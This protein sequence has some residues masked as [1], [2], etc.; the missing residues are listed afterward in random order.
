MTRPRRPQVRVQRLWRQATA[1][2]IPKLL[3]LLTASVIWFF[4]SEDRRATVEQSFEVPITVR[5]RTA[6]QEGGSTRAASQLTPETVRV[7]LSGRPERLGELRG[8]TIEAVI[9]LTG[10]P[11]GSFSRP[12]TVTAPPGTTLVSTVPERVQGFLDTVT[13]RTLP[14]TL[15]VIPPQG[16]NLPAYSVS[17]QQVTVSGPSRQV[18]AV[19][20]VVTVPEPISSGQSVAL[21]LLALDASGQAAD[22]K[23]S[24]Q[25]VSVTRVDSG[26]L[27]IRTVA[28]ELVPPPA[29]LSIK[30]STLTPQQVRLVGPSEALA[31]LEKVYGTV[32]YAPGSS[33]QAVQLRL[34]AGVEPL[35][36]V[37]ARLEV[38]RRVLQD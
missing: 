26:S 9:D 31:G 15:S 12:T 25:Q 11:E 14:V 24:P 27:P 16:N 21:R 30:N 6:G 1:D 34:P 36:T 23:L 2:L 3:A 8:E 10:L 17:P 32:G 38:E 20:A 22:V 19:Q 28:V 29:G 5:D 35:D 13:S 37:T 4:A 18:A 7:T 33:T